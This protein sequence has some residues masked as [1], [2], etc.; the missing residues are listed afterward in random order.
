[1]VTRVSYVNLLLKSD[2]LTVLAGR[3]PAEFLFFSTLSLCFEP[4]AVCIGVL[5]SVRILN[6]LVILSLISVA[7]VTCWCVW[8][9]SPDISTCPASSPSYTLCENLTQRGSSYNPTAR[10]VW[11]NAT[12]VFWFLWCLLKY[13]WCE[14]Y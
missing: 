3:I 11:H 4:W 6:I 8:C 7:P 12:I 1:M 14:F 13:G 10:L 9:S 2:I 5:C